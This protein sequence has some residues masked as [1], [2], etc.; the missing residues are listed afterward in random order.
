MS[1]YSMGYYGFSD[2]EYEIVEEE[3]PPQRQAPKSP[4]LRSHLRAITK[5]NAE[6]KKQLEEQKAMLQEL[7]SE[8]NPAAGGFQSG[9][10]QGVARPFASDAEQMQY[11]RLQQMGAMPAAPMGSE[12]EAIARIRNAKSPEEL[13][14]FL[15]SQGNTQGS[16]SYNGMGYQG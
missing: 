9:G 13:M 15:R 14:E 5:E 6:M 10:R 4:G 11:Q 8:E 12:A 1:D 2:D 16:Q 3:V 7:M